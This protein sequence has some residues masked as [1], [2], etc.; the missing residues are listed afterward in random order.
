MKDPDCLTEAELGE[1]LKLIPFLRMWAD[2]IETHALSL[3]L[4]GG[5]LP[6]FKLVAGRTNRMWANERAATDWLVYITSVAEAMPRKLISPAQAEK[7]LRE[8]KIKNWRTQVSEHTT[9]R[10]GSP[11]IARDTDPRPVLEVFGEFQHA[12]EAGSAAENQ[13]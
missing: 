1:L 4:K 12:D 8:H 2:T 10:A 6:G 13:E 5:T 9:Y 11:T 7:L 3:L